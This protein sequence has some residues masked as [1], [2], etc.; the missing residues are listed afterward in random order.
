MN[1]PS[2]A[3]LGPPRWADRLL[4]WLT[5]PDLLEELQ[6]DLHEQFAQRI[7]QVG[8]WR[9]RFWYGLEALKVIRPLL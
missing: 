8:P 1:K 9:A 6:G 2:S 5:P 7:D 4:S 3:P